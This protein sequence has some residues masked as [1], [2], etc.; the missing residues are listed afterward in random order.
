MKKIL[1]SVLA[2][3]LVAVLPVLA[4]QK[5]KKITNRYAMVL[6]PQED[7]SYALKDREKFKSVNLDSIPDLLTVY[8]SRPI[9]SGKEY[10]SCVSEVYVYKTHEGYDLRLIVDRAVS[11]RSSPFV[12]YIHGGGW[13]GGNSNAFRVTS[14]YI[15]VKKG[16]AGVRISYSLGGQPGAD[17]K[18]GME[19]IYDALKWVQ[20][21]AEELNIDPKCFAFCGHLAGAHLAA[22]A[23][24]T[25][26]GT[27]AFIG[28]AGPYDLTDP[29]VA[30]VKYANKKRREYFFSFKPEAS[31][32]YSPIHN[33]S[34]RN[35]PDALLIHGPRSDKGREILMLMADFL[36]RQ[37]KQ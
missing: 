23:A 35:V 31:R 26:K 36:E 30:A 7:G 13:A 5:P 24:L 20:D 3:A 16:I 33:V 1:L 6:E 19:D 15:A 18:V 22:M 28:N 8:E 17:I 4:Q 37:L 11:D 21:H 12:V 2:T 10:K 14:Q 25:V 34:R 29:E 9:A 32:L 27:T